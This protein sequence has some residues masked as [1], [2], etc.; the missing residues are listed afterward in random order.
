MDAAPTSTPA[1]PGSRLGEE[2]GAQAVEY[3]M[4]GGF[5]AGLIGLLWTIISKTGLIDRVVETLLNS[6]TDL[7]SSWF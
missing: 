1:P 5:G 7:V 2:D 6:L 4:I 3:A